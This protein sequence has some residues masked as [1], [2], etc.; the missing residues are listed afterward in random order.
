MCYNLKSLNI[1]WRIKMYI[2][3]ILIFLIILIVSREKLFGTKNTITEENKGS[4]SHISSTNWYNLDETSIGYWIQETLGFSSTEVNL[5]LWTMSVVLLLSILSGFL[6]WKWVKNRISINALGWIFITIFVGGI[7]YGIG[8]KNEHMQKWWSDFTFFEQGTTEKLNLYH[9]SQ[10]K[11]EK[12]KM[13]LYT[14]L[15]VSFPRPQVRNKNVTTTICAEISG[16]DILKQSSD[17]PNFHITL[18]G[19]KPGVWNAKLTKDVQEL[20]LRNN[21]KAVEV[22]FTLRLKNIILDGNVCSHTTF[23]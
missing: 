2:L 18:S 4:E 12:I 22:K 9:L 14:T 16:P 11:S 23:S 19:N 20:M 7:L 15:V 17:L 5:W 21:L 8:L 1:A 13:G 10:G 6:D 3:V